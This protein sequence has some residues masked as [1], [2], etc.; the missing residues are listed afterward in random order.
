VRLLCPLCRAARLRA[1]SLH[2]K[3]IG[4]SHI[5]HTPFAH[6]MPT[7]HRP[8]TWPMTNRLCA[9]FR[10]CVC[11]H[12]VPTLHLH[13]HQL[14]I[15]YSQMCYIAVVLSRRSFR[16]QT[17][18]DSLICRFGFRSNY[19]KRPGEDTQRNSVSVV[20]AL[21][22]LSTPFRS[23]ILSDTP[24]MSQHPSRQCHN[25]HPVWSCFI[26]VPPHHAVTAPT[27]SMSQ[28]PSRQ[29]H[30]THP[31]WSCFIFAS[32]HHSVT[33]PAPAMAQHPCNH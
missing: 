30:N 23:N 20:D 28:H 9:R 6:C 12:A 24:A 18:V 17:T 26:V 16:E 11:K 22:T 33:T 19:G 4:S 7:L 15:P 10:H 2:A 5:G 21:C 25:T 3:S 8:F 1:P 13:V 32:S 14:L 27:P 31:V 29:C